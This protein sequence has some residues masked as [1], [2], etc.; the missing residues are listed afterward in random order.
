MIAV[1]WSPQTGQI[2]LGGGGGRPGTGVCS[3][4][5]VCIPTKEFKLKQIA[6]IDCKDQRV[7]NMTY[8]PV[9][10]FEHFIY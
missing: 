5:F 1:E 10:F 2:Y 7:D 3:G 8:H 6:F 9:V 4:I